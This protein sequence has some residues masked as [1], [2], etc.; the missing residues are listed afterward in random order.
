MILI[1]EAELKDFGQLLPIARAVFQNSD[2]AGP[3][4]FDTNHI[5]RMFVVAM[6]TPN[7]FCQVVEKDGDIAGCMIGVVTETFW[8]DRLATDIF[9]FASIGT[10]RL[11]RNFKT[12]AKARGAIG[13]QITNLYGDDRY[14]KLIDR[15]GFPPVGSIH[16]EIF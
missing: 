7:F 15:V 1:R 14:D 5:R 2:F 3:G 9:T 16:L 10:D 4:V 11:L 6:A 8:G 13:V 12:W